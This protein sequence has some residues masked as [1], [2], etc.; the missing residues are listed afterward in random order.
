MAQEV[1]LA[2]F[3]SN[4]FN[5]TWGHYEAV[6]REQLTP[7][8]PDLATT[9][10]E[11]YPPTGDYF[12]PEY[13]YTSMV[14]DIRVTCPVQVLADVTASHFTSRVYRAVV[15]ASPSTPL[16]I[17]GSPARYAFHA[18]DIVAFFGDFQGLQYAPSKMDKEFQKVLRDQVMS[19]VRDG[20]PEAPVWDTARTCVALL[21]DHVFPVE[22]YNRN[23]CDFWLQN[24][25][26]SY[27]LIN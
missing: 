13:Q 11:I 20:R 6:V 8:S 26:F 18:W 5:W 2:P 22:Q 27:A 3:D 7:F 14:S 17:A 19:F 12:S 9:A 25:F 23:R 10:L 21:S 24:G 4:M 15:I 16:D 1:D